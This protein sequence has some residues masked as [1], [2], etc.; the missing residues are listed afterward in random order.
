MTRNETVASR[1][2]LAQRTHLLTESVT[3]F[4]VCGIVTVVIDA[5]ADA[6]SGLDALQRNDTNDVTCS[7]GKMKISVL[8]HESKS[9]LLTRVPLHLTLC[10]QN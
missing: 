3:N 6:G 5:V 1:F 2:P 8:D 9:T 7:Q 4:L 10:N